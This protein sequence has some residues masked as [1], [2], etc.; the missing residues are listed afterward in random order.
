M[1][2]KHQS[3]ECNVTVNRIEDVGRFTAD[4]R[5][6]CVECGTPFRFLGLPLGLDYNSATVSFDGTEA[7]M[8]IAPM[9][10]AVPPIKGV[11][12]FTIERHGR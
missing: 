12:G 6:M 3:F 8:G 9:G 5:V 2:C 10:D 11:E 7:R 4:V 1:S